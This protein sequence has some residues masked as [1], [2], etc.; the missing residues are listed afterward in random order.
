MKNNIYDYDYDELIERFKD[1]GIPKFRT[2]QVWNWLYVNLVTEYSE[3]TNISKKDIEKIEELYYIPTID[4]VDTKIANDSTEKVL[5]KYDKSKV[6]ESVLMKYKHGNSVC[7]TTQ[8]GC[9]VGCAFCA[10][11]LDGFDRN[12]TAGEI[13]AQVIFWQRHL[14]KIEERVS[15]IVVMGTGEPFHNIDNL[16][17]FIDIVNDQNGLKIGARHIT[18][19]TSGILEGI[20]RLTQYPKQVNLAISL[21]ATNDELRN[22]LI[23]I[24]KKYPISELL[25]EVKKYQNK[26]NRQVTFEYIMIQ[27]T[28]DSLENAA[29][30]VKLVRNFNCVV[31]LIKYNY[32]EEYDHEPPEEEQIEKFFDYLDNNRVHVTYRK[33]LGNNIDSACGQLRFKHIKESDA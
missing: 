25:T 26:T 14:K 18:I 5:I 2:S 32:V 22:T 10:S 3:M 12:L 23:P 9:K 27:D 6:I 7:V 33:Q 21:H 4:V 24:N 19:S 20:K 15:H 17:N 31:N 29:E 16:F 1:L 11:C 28:N 8:I 13:V 30:L